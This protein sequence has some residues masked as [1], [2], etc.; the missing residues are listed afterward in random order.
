MTWCC[1]DSFEER[2]ATARA[3]YVASHQKRKRPGQTPAGFQKA[4]ARLPV[5]CLRA[6]AAGVRRRLATELGEDLIV[7]GFAPF[8]CD[9]AR[10]ECPRTEELEQRLGQSG[11]DGSAPMVWLTALVHLPTGLLWGWWLGRGRADERWHLRQLLPLLPAAVPVLL[12][13]DAGYVSYEVMRAI[14]EAK[15]DFL[16]R[17]SSRAYLYTEGGTELAK[18]T[19]G[20]VYYWPVRAQE[21]KQPP[22]TVRLLRVRGRGKADV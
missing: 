10:V 18:F 11:K 19:E 9:G 13:A 14:L 22:L 6:V 5:A 8:G 7:D 3:F 12:V 2:F 4:L 15:A 17:M 21:Q 1:G 16:I 20:V